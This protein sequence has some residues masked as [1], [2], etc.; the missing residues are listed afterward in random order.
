MAQKTCTESQAGPPDKKIWVDERY[1]SYERFFDHDWARRFLEVSQGTRF[2]PAALD[3][4]A[5]WKGAASNAS[6]PWLLIFTLQSFHKGYMQRNEPFWRRLT[7]AIR[8][9]IIGNKS[10]SLSNRQRKK[11]AGVIDGLG[12]QVQHEMSQ[13]PPELSA[14]QVWRDY[15]TIP[16]FNL[17]LW[18]SQRICYGAIYHAY[19]NFLREFASIKKP[20]LR[21]A[22]AKIIKVKNALADILG[23]ATAYELLEEN[24]V[25]IARLVRNALAHNGGRAST[26][27][28][29]LRPALMIERCVIQIMAPDVRQLVDLLKKKVMLVAEQAPTGLR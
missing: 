28:L 18:S 23:K 13:R 1:A 19:E 16:E 15:L 14:E 2:N 24:G 20:Q 12:L 22:R 9:H 7:I 10:I 11:L 5:D 17:A 29:S 3:L 4:C 25:V 6:M 8:Q 21:D 27:L 26:E